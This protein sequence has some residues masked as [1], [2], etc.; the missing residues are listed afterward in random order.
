MSE[1]EYIEGTV[2]K[3][4]SKR[5]GK[6][7]YYNFTLVDD[8]TLYRTGTEEPD[9]A[10]GDIIA[11]EV[12]E[13]EYGWDVDFD[14]IEITG[15]ED[16]PEEKPRRSKKKASRKKTSSKKKSSKKAPRRSG[17][18]SGAGGTT[19]DD[20]WKNKE[21]A[22]IARQRSISYNAALNTALE[23]VSKEYELGIAVLKKT[24]K[25]QDKVDAF[26]ALVMEKA[27][28]LWVKF[29][30][31]GSVDPSKLQHDDVPEVDE[32]DEEEDED[33]DNE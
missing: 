10:R 25:V 19:K 3:V 5:V 32:D 31:M 20:Y 15:E 27:E 8:D 1:A 4:G 14:S 18:K 7:T 29:N 6:N 12:T 21:Q 16:L 28:E 24:G 17:G 11:F 13:S 26:E 22:D 23:M 9:I 30:A 33:W 2:N